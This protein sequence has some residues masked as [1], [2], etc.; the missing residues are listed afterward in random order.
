MSIHPTADKP[1]GVRV[2]RSPCSCLASRWNWIVARAANLLGDW[3]KS[4]FSDYERRENVHSC[5]FLIIDCWSPHSNIVRVLPH[6]LVSSRLPPPSDHHQPNNNNNLWNFHHNNNERHQTSMYQ[7]FA[8][9]FN[10]LHP[11]VFPSPS[12]CTSS[13][14]IVHIFHAVD[15]AQQNNTDWVSRQ[16]KLKC[17]FLQAPKANSSLFLTCEICTFDA[18]NLILVGAKC[19]H[20]G[21][22]PHLLAA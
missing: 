7:L 22:F 2:Q 5:G 19:K 21:I 3:R 16:W 15:V 10:S 1:Q 6:A 8:I 14:G 9:T 11:L 4:K 12:T 17:E 20:D 18:I 13:W